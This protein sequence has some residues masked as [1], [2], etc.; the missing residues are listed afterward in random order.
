MGNNFVHSK[1]TSEQDKEWKNRFIY[2]P[3]AIPIDYNTVIVFDSNL[4]VIERR[5]CTKEENE[6]FKETESIK[7]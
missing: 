6:D 5:P 7:K 4:N 2:T 1:F 3:D